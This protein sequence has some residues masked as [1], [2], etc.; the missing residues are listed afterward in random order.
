MLDV[1]QMRKNKYLLLSQTIIFFYHKIWKHIPINKGK[2]SLNFK[3]YFW[4]RL[5]R[6]FGLQT[7]GKFCGCAGHWADSKIH[8]SMY[9]REIT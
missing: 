3:T 8:D 2:R 7:V 4:R 6:Y 1:L 5:N 9:T